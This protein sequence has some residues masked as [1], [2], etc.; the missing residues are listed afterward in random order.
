MKLSSLNRNRIMEGAYMWQVP[1]EFFEP[2]YN[3]L[4]HGWEP[5]GCFTAVLA[6]DFFMAVQRSHPANTVEAF[7]KTTGWIND[8]WPH[9]AWGS[10]PAVDA[11]IKLREKDRRQILEDTG[12]IYTERQEVEMALRG[13]VAGPEPVLW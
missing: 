5:G 6:N 1:K 8:K 3:Y 2:F 4:V 10:Y 11:W 7:K 9:T 13:K 12:L